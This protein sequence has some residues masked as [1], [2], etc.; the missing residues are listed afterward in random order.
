MPDN[1][2]EILKAHQKFIAA[3][4]DNLE[5]CKSDEERYFLIDSC[6]KV[7]I[8]IGVCL[9]ILLAA[10]IEDL[11]LVL[12]QYKKDISLSAHELWDKLRGDET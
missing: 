7:Q 3:F 5:R 9:C 6:S 11:H 12:E 1:F 2:E 10:D 8:K 4:R